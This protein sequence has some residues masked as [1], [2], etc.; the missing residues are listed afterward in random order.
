MIRNSIR[1]D[2]NLLI[3]KSGSA[4]NII[5]ALNVF[6]FL[7]I[8]IIHWGEWAFATGSN[9]YFLENWILNN[10]SLPGTFSKFILKPWTLLTYI[11]IH[12]EILHIFFN[13]VW[14][15]F[16][17]KIFEEYLGERKFTF[18]FLFG[19]IAGGLLF[20]TLYKII[21]ALA[22]FAS[23][24]SIIGAS[25][26]VMAIIVSTATL[27]P[28]YSIFILF[29]GSVQLK[30]IAI[31]YLILDFILIPYGNAGGHISH[32]GGAIFGF[33]YISQLNRGNDW[34]IPFIKLFKK[35]RKSHLK[36]VTKFTP[37][38][39]EKNNEQLVNDILDKISKTGIKSLTDKEK[40]I[41][42]KASQEF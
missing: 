14:L 18:V 8:N 42:K 4:I 37:P 12:Q 22:P 21:P 41:L 26:G 15:F 24:S 13:M 20:M 38:I 40:Q 25:A 11:F 3:F 33:L 1:N 30:W 17:G 10:A 28:N 9:R 23:N 32:L 29:I 6:L 31:V 19:G 16:I 7:L 39:T 5:I 34:A 36:V 27:L 35:R 2:L